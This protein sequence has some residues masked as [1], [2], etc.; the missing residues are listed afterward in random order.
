[1]SQFDEAKIYD[2]DV[3]FQKN[4]KTPENA[5]V[6]IRLQ[7][8]RDEEELLTKI[9]KLYDQKRSLLAMLLK[10]CM[11]EVKSYQGRKSTKHRKKCSQ[12]GGWYDQTLNIRP[13]HDK[14][15][16]SVDHTSR[17]PS[18]L[19][20]SVNNDSGIVRNLG[21]EDSYEFRRTFDSPET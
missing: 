6:S 11:D 2:L 5:S 12:F 9:I 21:N 17:D 14:S 13:D 16:V 19:Y 10:K 1:M 4:F 18:L 3:K 20:D 8:I 7:Y 15:L